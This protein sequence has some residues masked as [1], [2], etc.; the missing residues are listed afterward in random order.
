MADSGKKLLY[1]TLG[2]PGDLYS[3]KSFVEGELKAL[4]K[5]FDE[6]VLVPTDNFGWQAGY[7][8]KLPERVSVDKSLCLDK[9]FASRVRKARYILHPEMLGNL[10]RMRGEAK[11]TAQ[12]IKGFFQSA[13]I[14]HVSKIIKKI[15]ARHNMTPRNTVLMSMWFHDAAGALAR[16]GLKE[17]WHVATH[18]HTS[19]LYDDRMLFRSKNLRNRLLNGVDRVFSIS[20]RGTEYMRN[21]YPDHAHKIA[22][23]PLGSTRLFDVS[24][25]TTDE[26]TSG[27]L[28]FA[29]VARVQEVK[30]HDLILETLWELAALLPHHTVTWEVIG[31]GEELDALKALA[32]KKKR[33]NFQVIFTGALEN[34]EI[35]KRFSQ[36]PPQ[37]FLMMSKT[38]GLPVSMG[39]AMSYGI[40]VI[41]TD[42]GDIRELVTPQCAIILPPPYPGN[43][44]D[45]PRRSAKEYALDLKSAVT[46]DELRKKLGR[47]ALAQW[48]A[49]FNAAETSRRLVAEL[50]GLLS[51]TT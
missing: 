38:E 37:W 26:E 28:T 4:L 43:N 14:L 36:H 20:K 41:T 30:C 7:A 39:E 12:W 10:L 49:T 47:A 46:D 32:D 5:E 11:S 51:P 34:K 3:E 25:L 6:I 31:D 2:Y 42:V 48:E 24:K 27:L 21:R 22:T 18:A 8:E 35:Q 1:I 17:G 50:S 16:L 44:W 45:A 33:D 23:S 29:T 13:N 15:A 40:P 19:D 9:V